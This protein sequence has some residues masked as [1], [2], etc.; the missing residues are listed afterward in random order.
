MKRQPKERRGNTSVSASELATMGRCER[1][2]VLMRRPGP[3]TAH[4]QRAARLRGVR[5]HLEFQAE[6]ERE[7]IEQQLRYPPQ[8]GSGGTAPA[9]DGQEMVGGEGSGLRTVALRLISCVHQHLRDRQ[10]L[11]GR[12]LWWLTKRWWPRSNKTAR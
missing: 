3:G 1:Q 12:Q 7:L 11:H 9:L 5:A 2:I 8:G 10:Q 4:L 6:G